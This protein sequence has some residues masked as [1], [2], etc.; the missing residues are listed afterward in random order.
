MRSHSPWVV[1]AH[2]IKTDTAS[3]H[4]VDTRSQ[5]ANVNN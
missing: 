5:Q 4:K 2:D 3:I 1:I